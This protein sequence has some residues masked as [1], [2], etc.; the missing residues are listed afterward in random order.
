[1]VVILSECVGEEGRYLA[2]MDVERMGQVVVERE[3]R[4]PARLVS[5][6]S[7]PIKARLC[8]LLDAATQFRDQLA[9][10]PTG[11]ASFHYSQVCR[12]ECDRTVPFLLPRDLYSD[13]STFSGLLIIPDSSTSSIGLDPIVNDLAFLSNNGLPLPSA[14]ACQPRVPKD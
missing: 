8:T 7:T 4:E 1:M 3:A 10:T 9:R 6:P 2:R 13:L 11:S 14:A 12:T 5:L